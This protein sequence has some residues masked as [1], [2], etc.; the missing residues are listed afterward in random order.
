MFELLNCL[1]AALGGVYLLQLIRPADAL[2]L[3]AR[4]TAN[5]LPSAA[6]WTSQSNDLRKGSV[7]A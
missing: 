3:I 6:V 4:P 2:A 7:G 5:L 1:V